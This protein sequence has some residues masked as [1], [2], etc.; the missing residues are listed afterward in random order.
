[1]NRQERIKE[2]FL[3]G[4]TQKDIGLIFGIS[5][6][7]VRVILAKE[8]SAD[9]K[10][11]IVLRNMKL[12][13]VDRKNAVKSFKFKCKNCGKIFKAKYVKRKFCSTT[14]LE[15]YRD[16]NRKSEEYKKMKQKEAS[17]RHYLKIKNS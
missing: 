2:Y 1:M 9:E 3:K 8:F 7:M 14:C 6:E 16:K 11:E 13:T 17:K 12:K 4:K 10:R 5:K 15:I